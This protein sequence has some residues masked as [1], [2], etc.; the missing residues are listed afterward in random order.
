MAINEWWAGDP[1]ERYWLEVTDR[2]DVGTDL[3]APETDVSGQAKWTYALV[4]FVGDGDAVFHYEL[5]ERAIT[6]WSL[7]AG[8][9]WEDETIWAAHGTVS[10]DQTPF[11]R[12]GIYHGLHGPFALDEPLTL[13]VLRAGEERLRRVVSEVEAAHGGSLYLPFQFRQDQ[14][15]MGQGYL[16]KMPSAV[17][18]A[19]SQLRDATPREASQIERPGPSPP[20]RRRRYRRANEDAAI[21]ERDPF[22]VDP[23]VVERGVRGHARTQNQLAD[24]VEALGFL[25]ERP[26]PDDPKYDLLWR[27]GET[28]YVAEVKS[29]TEANEE[30]QLRLGLGQL[31]RYRHGLGR[32]GATVQAMLVCER[33]P[34]DRSWHE[35][36]SGLGV[37]LVWPAVLS[38]RVRGPA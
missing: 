11:A 38:D 3:H 14:L 31:L 15:R 27:D 24:H 19:F 28:V 5:A 20:N 12:P 26:D 21:P 23:A 4:R 22:P 36:C 35:L 8:G 37:E 2:E 25:P 7:A 9:S 18:S 29:L 6:S 34:T 33:E 30:R 32:A 1:S 17:V 16:F 10:R 13:A